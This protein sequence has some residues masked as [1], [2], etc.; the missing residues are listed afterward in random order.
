PSY[1]PAQKAGFRSRRRESDPSSLSDWSLADP[2]MERRVA[3]GQAVADGLNRL[4]AW[5][6][7]R[8]HRFDLSKVDVRTPY[9]L[10]PSIKSEDPL[11]VPGH[12]HQA[13]LAP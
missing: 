3:F 7:C 9:A 10:L 6:G 8:R 13:P 2:A 1:F 4:A 5:Q 12:R 11:H